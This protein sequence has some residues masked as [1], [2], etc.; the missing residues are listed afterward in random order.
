MEIERKFLIKQL[1]SHLEEYPH[2]Q[3]SQAYV[4]TEPVIRI[5]R[6]NQDFILTIKSGGMLAREEIEMPIPEK[7]FAHL[8]TKTDGIII[9]KTRYKIPESHGYLIEL[10]VFHGVYEGFIMAE[11]EFPDLDAAN[12]YQAPPWFGKDVTMDSR[13]HNSNLSKRSSEEVKDFL[14]ALSQF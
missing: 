13:F 8:L 3:I 4:C 5:R 1:P 11:I 7:S 12:H 2:D 9:E 6:K 10:D 14:N